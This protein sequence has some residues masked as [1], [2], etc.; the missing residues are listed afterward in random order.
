MGQTQCREVDS[1][2]GI[3]FE[4]LYGDLIANSENIVRALDLSVNDLI[5]R[6]HAFLVGGDL[7]QCATTHESADSTREL[8]S[9]FDVTGEFSDSGDSISNCHT[10]VCTDQDSTV[11]LNVD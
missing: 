7:N 11:L 4:H 2:H 8:R 3:D 10:V 1:T 5:G 6:D 9:D